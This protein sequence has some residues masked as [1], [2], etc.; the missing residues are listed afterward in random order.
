MGND[1]DLKH[2][3]AIGLIDQNAKV[4]VLERMN[5]GGFNYANCLSAAQ[6]KISVNNVVNTADKA[7]AGLNSMSSSNNY[8]PNAANRY[9]E[10]RC[11]ACNT[12]G[13]LKKECPYLRVMR[14]VMDQNR[15]QNRGAQNNAQSFPLQRKQ[16][17]PSGMGNGGSRGRFKGNGKPFHGRNFQRGMNAMGAEEGH[18]SG[19]KGDSEAVKSE[20]GTSDNFDF[21]PNILGGAVADSLNSGN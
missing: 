15:A 4:F 12:V 7:A 1:Y 18:P 2:Q 17:K 6:N 13:H 21:D 20:Q 8:T 19:S 16:F 10:K 5:D 9:S 3:F 11:Y 14:Y